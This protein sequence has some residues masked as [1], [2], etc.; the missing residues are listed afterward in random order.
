MVILQNISY[1]HTDEDLLF[2][3]INLTINK[4]DKTALI[5]NNG[6]GKSTLLK[7]IAGILK[8]SGGTVTV[9]S[10]PYYIPQLFGQ[11]N[12][13]SIAHALK[14]KGK[15]NALK[16]ILDGKINET[17]LT[18]LD[19]DWMIEE[20]CQEALTYWKLDGLD[21]TQKLGTLSGGQ[22]TKIFLAG[23]FIHQPELI[24]MDE[25]G[26]HLDVQNRHLLNDF[27]RTTSSTLIVVSHD[28]KLLNMLHPVHEL[29]RQ[30]ITVYGG[31]YNFYVAQKR[32][33]SNALNENVHRKENALRKAREMER[34]TAEKKQKRDVRGRKKHQKE[35]LPAVVMNAL[36]NKSEKST[37]RIKDIH[38]EKVGSISR[39]LHQL[40]KELPG[41]DKMKFDFN[42]SLLHRGKILVHVKNVNVG[43]DRKLLWEQPVN[44][45]I[46]SGERIAVRG[47]NGSGKT[48]LIKTILG[49]IEPQSGFV[50]RADIKAVYIDQDYSLIDDQFTVLGQAQQFNSIPLQ[51]HEIKARLNRFLF[52]KD[53]WDKPCGVLSG[54]EKMRLMLCSLNI[55]N[56]APDMIILDE[57]TNNLDIQNMEILTAAISDY[58]G[59]L[60]VISHDEYFLEQ[61]NI[62]R[63]IDLT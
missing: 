56:Q 19:D 36:K 20:R 63:T 15:L 58:Q 9:E 7:I 14:I 60:M 4:H 51:E 41:V 57:P 17:N 12:E 13:H 49:E 21:L 10:K 26:N 38:A 47:P 6:V 35:G 18:Q 54:G 39:E 33:E 44:F 29:S 16:E 24:L 22:K 27:I 37:A 59:T 55:A 40:R 1:I 31:N 28:R 53:Y 11:F 23:M 46:R 61:I 62:K 50:R 30:G 42:N 48:T 52:P 45:M 25:P 3:N 43:Y 5:G 8:P 2:D 32:I 34:K